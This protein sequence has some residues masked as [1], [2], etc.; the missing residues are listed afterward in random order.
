MTTKM[1]ALLQKHGLTEMPKDK[2]LFRELRKEYD[3]MR[4]KE[5]REKRGK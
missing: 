4:I 1:E 2:K 3:L 5:A